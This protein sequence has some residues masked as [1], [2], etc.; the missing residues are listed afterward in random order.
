MRTYDRK[1]ADFL[2]SLQLERGA[3]P[4]TIEAY[5]R[6]LIDL[7]DFVEHEDPD[8]ISVDVLDEYAVALRDR[9]L[10]PATVRRRLAAVRAFLKHRAREGGRPD[11]GR[12]VPLP[13]LG[14]RLPEP[15][16][17]AEA[18]AVV[19]RPDAS[20]RG[21][22]DRAML[23]L[24]YGAGLRV[25]ELVTLRVSDVDLEEGVVRCRGKGAKQRVVPMGRGAV[26]AI[27][28]YM[29]RGR[30][31]LGRK[32]RGDSLFLNHRGQGIT[33]QAVFQLVR[34]HARTAGIKKTVTP[35]TMRHSFATHLLE[36]GCD[37]R[38]VQEMLGH[39]TIETTQVY[40]HVSAEHVR[41]AYFKAHPR[42]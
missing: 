42:A 4:H 29:Q 28:M 12:T 37:L 18:E 40:T 11:A 8:T 38:S 17:P 34:D 6:D 41:E 5:R 31:Y 15:L 35:H 7:G 22:R 27:R 24:L 20:P 25:S 13:R 39:A 23:E 33:R 19:T 16:T 36:G 2:A 30:P 9:G 1:L 21:L 14:R 32:Q 3:S 10:S 26:D